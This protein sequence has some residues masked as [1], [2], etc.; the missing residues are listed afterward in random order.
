MPVE[1]QTRQGQTQEHDGHSQRL[2]Q[3]GDTQLATLTP[4]KPV[5]TILNVPVFYKRS[6]PNYHVY[7]NP[8]AELR[9]LH[10]P[11]RNCSDPPEFRLWLTL[12]HHS[13]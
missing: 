8:A 10:I 5:A 3:P 12:E 7:T 9:D 13:I 1:I 11:R 2:P 6:T 4:P